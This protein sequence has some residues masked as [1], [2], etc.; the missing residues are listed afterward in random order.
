[1]THQ[2][3]SSKL[4]LWW[5]RQGLRGFWP[6]LGCVGRCRFLLKRP[7]WSCQYCR[8]RRWF[9]GKLDPKFWRWNRFLNVIIPY[10]PDGKA[11]L[12]DVFFLDENGDTLYLIYRDP[13]RR[14]LSLKE[15]AFKL[16]ARLCRKFELKRG[17]AYS[18]G[19][20]FVRKNVFTLLETAAN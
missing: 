1:M 10:C 15:A 2:A 4:L 6:R 3:F 18:K 20:L 19:Y 17:K 14:L 12:P 16:L 11:V 8:L 9:Y 13:R 7:H 5:R